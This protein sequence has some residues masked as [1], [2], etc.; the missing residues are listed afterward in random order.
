TLALPVVGAAHAVELDA[1]RALVGAGDEAALDRSRVAEP[2]GRRRAAAL[3]HA[4][5]RRDEVGDVRAVDDG[6]AAA[7]ASAAA[8]ARSPPAARGAEP[9]LPLADEPER[10]VRVV[11]RGLPGAVV[12]L[13]P[14]PE[15]VA[16]DVPLEDAEAD[17]HV[18]RGHVA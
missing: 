2:S 15:A 7:R 4:E 6:A 18:H 13:E 11:Q 3:D 8:P 16:R 14:A 10:R 12:G 1:V 9:R 17:A 5:A